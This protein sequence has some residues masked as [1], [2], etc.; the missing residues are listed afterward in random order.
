MDDMDDLVFDITRYFAVTTANTRKDLI[1]T[2][3][4]NIDYSLEY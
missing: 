4:I 3:M 1:Q 2:K